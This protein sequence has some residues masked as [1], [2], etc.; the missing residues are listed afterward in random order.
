LLDKLRKHFKTVY[1]KLSKTELKGRKLEEASEDFKITLLTNDVALEVAD[2]ISKNVT[3]YLCDIKVPR[4]ADKRKVV[5]EA[6]F[7]VLNEV[8]Q[9]VK[10]LDLEKLVMDRVKKGEITT[11]LF[12]GVNGTGKTTTIAKLAHL[13]KKKGLIVVLACSDT[14]RAGSMEQLEEHANRLAV[15]VIKHK[16]GADAA[17]VAFDAV[18][19]AQSKGANLVMIDTAGRMQTDRNL[20]DE[21][22]KISRVVKPELKILVVDALT[23][24]DAVKQC[25]VFNEHIGVDGVILTKLDADAKGGA[26]L[27]VIAEIG[28]PIIYI[29][30]G[31][32]YEDI[33][34]FKPSE[35]IN[36]LIS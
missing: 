15:K 5:K 14:F 17:A 20:M 30:T 28:K 7:H 11:L 4:T 27:S 32:S 16:Y 9:D 21:A 23:A 18:N 3:S 35:L 8:F 34:P 6:F 36:T 2:K 31:Q 24:N 13:F 26:A 12:L 29:G 22:E 19:Y 33:E 1:E 10:S 25:R